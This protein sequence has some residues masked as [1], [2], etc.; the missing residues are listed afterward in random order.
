MGEIS[1]DEIEFLTKNVNDYFKLSKYFY[2]KL[3]LKI[4]AKIKINLDSNIN[5]FSSISKIGKWYNYEP[6][7]SFSN[8]KWEKSFSCVVF[9]IRNHQANEMNFTIHID[10]FKS[11]LFAS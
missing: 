5:G 9:C 3:M 6:Y 11:C 7:I 2:E 1:Q 8:K 10:F 4:A